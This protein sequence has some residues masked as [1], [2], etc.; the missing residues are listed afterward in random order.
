MYVYMDFI[1]PHISVTNSPNVT[2]AYQSHYSKLPSHPGA[3]IPGR[4]L[5]DCRQPIEVS[6]HRSAGDSFHMLPLPSPKHTR[7]EIRLAAQSL[8]IHDSAQICTEFLTILGG[9][10]SKRHNIF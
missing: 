7:K 1:T 3:D 9:M 6:D 5:S 8:R 10:P 2:H 4:V